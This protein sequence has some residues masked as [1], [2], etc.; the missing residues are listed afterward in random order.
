MDAD[1]CNELE[2]E[3]L[4]HHVRFHR[5]EPMT[6]MTPDMEAEVVRRLRSLQW[7]LLSIARR[8]HIAQRKVVR[9]LNDSARQETTTHG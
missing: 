6:K 4:L 8:L 3:T 2:I 7:S 5:N 1:R 9:Y